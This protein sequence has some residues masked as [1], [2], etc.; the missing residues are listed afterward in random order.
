MTY[1]QD[2]KEVFNI[3]SYENISYLVL[4]NYEKLLEP[5][6]YVDGH[7]DIDLLCANSQEIVQSLGAKT[8]RKDQPPFIGDGTHYFIF[9]AGQR[10]SLDLRYIGDDYY[11]EKWEKDLLDRRVKFNGFFIMNDE[12]YFYSLIYH[13]VLQKESLS[14]EYLSRLLSMAAK[15]GVS[16]SEQSEY[17]LL[18]SLEVFMQ[19]HSYSF[20]YPFDYLVPAR[21]GLIDQ[22]MIRTNMCRKLC[23][24]RHW[25]KIRFIEMLV[26]VKHSLQRFL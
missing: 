3:L 15:L 6:M 20:V 16:L 4:R 2:I 10:V 21:F 11:C 7:G 22:S 26:Y 12:D 24:K 23:H 5:E 1:F 9:V 8:D 17:G 19:K 18:R 25:V 14:E 13:A